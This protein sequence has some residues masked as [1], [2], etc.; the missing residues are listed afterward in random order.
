MGGPVRHD[1]PLSLHFQN[2]DEVIG[3]DVGFVFSPLFWSKQPLVRPLSQEIN[4]SLNERI[5]T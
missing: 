2:R 1:V 4:A 3:V 5:S